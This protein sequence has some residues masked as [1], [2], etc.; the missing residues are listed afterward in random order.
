MTI[1]TIDEIIERARSVLQ[2]ENSE[3]AA[4]P[5][6]GNLYAIFRAIGTLVAEQDTKLNIIDDSLFLNT[7]TGTALEQK[8]A[9]FGVSRLS[10]TSAVG[11]VIVIG[12]NTTIPI[13]T[14]L[15]DP[16]TNFQYRTLSR[17]ISRSN[18]A[19][20]NVESLQRTVS[21]NVEAG[22]ILRSSLFPAAQF[23]VGSTYNPI[24]DLYEGN[25][26]GGS[27]RESDTELRS[28][29]ESV[30]R[31][32]ATGNRISIRETAINTSGISRVTVAD[33]TPS[34][35]FF[36][37]YVDTRNQDIIRNLQI[38][39]DNVKPIGTAVLIRSFTIVDIDII[40]N[41]TVRSTEDTNELIEEL[42]NSLAVYV[43]DLT[44]G[45]VLTKEGIAGT[46]LRN[47]RVINVE[48]ISPTSSETVRDNQLFSLRNVQFRFR[49]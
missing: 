4:F 36:T 7:A 33:N 30:I 32:I 38:N 22:I 18:R 48:V 10:G 26:S 46:L 37:V 6:Y 17:V 21:A 20:V 28:R 40:V 42:E 34:L 44:I 35:G 23:I 16:T 31:S 29:T 41:V 47:S 43:D 49:T 12:D 25:I 14:V 13:N 27:E 15:T 45:S 5:P 1:R 3:L 39:I 11:D 19:V 9:E 2:S 8:A 24:S